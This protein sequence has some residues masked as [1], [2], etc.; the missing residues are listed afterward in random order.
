MGNSENDLACDLFGVVIMAVL[1]FTAVFAFLFKGIEWL[2]GN[3]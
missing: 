3:I 2:I 1:Y